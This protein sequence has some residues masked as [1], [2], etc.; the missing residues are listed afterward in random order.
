MC[1]RYVRS[2]NAATV[3]WTT[4]AL[5]AGALLALQLLN[6]VTLNGIDKDG[7]YSGGTGIYPTKFLRAWVCREA[8]VS[9]PRVPSNFSSPTTPGKVQSADSFRMNMSAM[10]ANI[11]YPCSDII[12]FNKM[13]IRYKYWI[14]GTFSSAI[15]V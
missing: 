12:R 13:N 8:E 10:S 2:E 11:I 14:M 7:S 4:H 15:D 6:N 5:G 1:V 9:R 3:E